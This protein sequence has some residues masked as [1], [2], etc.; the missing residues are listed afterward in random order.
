MEVIIM[1]FIEDDIDEVIETEKAK[2]SKFA[3]GFDLTQREYNLICEMI[4]VRKI[5]GLTQKELAQSLAFKQQVISRIETRRE[6]PSLRNVLK[7]SD[8]LGLDPNRKRCL[9]HSH[10]MVPFMC[11]AFHQINRFRFSQEYRR[12]T[13]YF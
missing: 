1:P 4:K 7:I 8:A 10:S 6:V 9:W 2:D 11:R 5:K 12:Q 13:E 3:K